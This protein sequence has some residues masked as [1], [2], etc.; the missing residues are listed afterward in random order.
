MRDMHCHI[1]PGVD[2]GARNITESC[3]MLYAARQA[4]VTEIV[5]TPHCRD[6]Y[7]DYEGMWQAFELFRLHARGFPVRMGFEVNH[8]KLME[9]GIEWA[10]RLHFDGTNEFLLELSTRAAREDFQAY[11]RTIFEL[12]GRGFE[13]IIAHP[14]RYRAIQKDPG[15]AQDLVR[16]GCKL[17]ASA[18]FI[19]GGRLGKE[20]RP[21]KR[22]F[23]QGLYTYIASDAHRVQH[24]DYLARAVREY[25]DCE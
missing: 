10:D 15:I 4:G 12:Q 1:L 3:Q 25:G 11:E 23:A 24:Y 17:Q 20:K 14:E 7:F 22:L 18:D 9:L 13:V 5:C 6:P 21:A 2:D 19:A 16:M 8:T